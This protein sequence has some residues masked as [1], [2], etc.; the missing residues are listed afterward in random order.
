MGI[1]GIVGE[2]HRTATAKPFCE[3]APQAKYRTGGVGSADFGVTGIPISFCLR[4][5]NRTERRVGHVQR[6]SK[7]FIYFERTALDRL[8]AFQGELFLVSRSSV[9]LWRKEGCKGISQKVPGIF[10]NDSAFL[11]D[12]RGQ[13]RNC[14][15]GCRTLKTRGIHE[16]E[17]TGRRPFQKQLPAARLSFLLSRGISIGNTDSCAQCHCVLRLRSGRS[18]QKAVKSRSPNASAALLL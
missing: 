6:R 13:N 2:R 8:R 17:Q 9:S 11:R 16:P 3:L 12:W 14:G 4:R 5:G 1:G 18:G 10:S 15:R 7:S